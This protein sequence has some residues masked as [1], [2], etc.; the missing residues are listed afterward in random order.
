VF[1]EDYLR[2]GPGAGQPYWPGHAVQLEGEQPP[3][4]REL[5]ERFD[6]GSIRAALPA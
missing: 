3:A 1:E 2:E 4:L 5:L 6:R